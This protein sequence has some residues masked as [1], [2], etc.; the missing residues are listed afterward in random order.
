M[1][2]QLPQVSAKDPVITELRVL[3][4]SA[5]SPLAALNKLYELQQR[6]RE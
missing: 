2:F 3:D 1:V 5:V 6:V 4:A